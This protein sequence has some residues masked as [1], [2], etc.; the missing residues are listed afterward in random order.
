MLARKLN[1][2]YNISD[3]EKDTYLKRGF[4]IVDEKGNLIEASADKKISYAEHLK[5]LEEAKANGSNEE[6][7]AKVAELEKALEEANKVP[8]NAKELKEANAE[9]TAALEEANKTIEELEAKI[10]ELGAADGGT[11]DGKVQE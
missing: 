5:A 3:V 2:V 8:K 1:R 4:D 7:E 9:L 10:V 6:L 11:S